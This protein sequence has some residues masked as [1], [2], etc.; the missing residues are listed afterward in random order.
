MENK[1][2]VFRQNGANELQMSL[3]MCSNSSSFESVSSPPVLPDGSF[4]CTTPDGTPPHGVFE[5]PDG[6][7]GWVVCFA[8]FW[9]NLFQAGIAFSHGVIL[10][11]LIDEF[12][13]KH[14]SVALIG[15]LLNGFLLGVGPLAS[16]LV[17]RCVSFL[18]DDIL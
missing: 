6:G 12:G 5:P 8:C 4:S 9:L 7:Y 16:L 3:C 2:A 15:S 10:N 11:P 13:E 1:F 17:D 14:A 18:C